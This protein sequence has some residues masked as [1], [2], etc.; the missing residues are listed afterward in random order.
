MPNIT[1]NGQTTVSY[2]KTVENFFLQI[3]GVVI[4]ATVTDSSNNTSEFSTC[5]PYTDDTIFANGFEP[6]LF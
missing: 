1:V 6:G 5:F 4:T 3:S 2:S